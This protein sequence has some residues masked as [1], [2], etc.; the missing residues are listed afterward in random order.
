MKNEVDSQTLANYF[1]C[2]TQKSLVT[3][4]YNAD[5]QQ[6][7]TRVLHNNS[8]PGTYQFSKGQFNQDGR[9]ST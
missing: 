5:K 3:E 2:I 9:L 7:Y 8:I 6:H 4:R 1:K